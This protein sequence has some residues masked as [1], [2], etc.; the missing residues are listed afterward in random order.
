MNEP[1]FNNYQKGSLNMKGGEYSK[2]NHLKLSNKFYNLKE[3]EQD[4]QKI[5]HF[6]SKGDKR[7]IHI[8]G[9]DGNGKC[10][11]TKFAV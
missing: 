3:R 1:I 2:K 6:I 7:L 9:E 4:I 11:I 5:V 8:Y 10:D